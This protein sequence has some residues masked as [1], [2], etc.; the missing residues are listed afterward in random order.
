MSRT[1]FLGFSFQFSPTVPESRLKD[2]DGIR[3]VGDGEQDHA[4][5]ATATETVT[6]FTAPASATAHTSLRVIVLHGSTS[7]PAPPPIGDRPPGT[8]GL[9]CR[10]P[11][12]LGH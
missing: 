5:T 2:T 8:R 1:S 12:T 7:T 6:E 10:L 11:P 9:A 4:A 3:R